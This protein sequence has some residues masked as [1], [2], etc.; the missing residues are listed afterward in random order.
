[1]KQWDDRLHANEFYG[2]AL[3]NQADFELYSIL[4][5]KHNS[6]SFQRFME[7]ELSSKSLSW[8]VRMQVRCKHE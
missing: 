4:K 8:F 1:M 5:A 6:R 7:K 2:G 3:P